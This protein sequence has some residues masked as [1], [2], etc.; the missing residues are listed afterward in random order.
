MLGEPC[1]VAPCER[2]VVLE[3]AFELVEHVAGSNLS[4]DELYRV[5]KMSFGKD[6]DRTRI[7]YNSHMTLDGIPEEASG[8]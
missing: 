6:K 5:E 4:D 8:T 1:D 2:A 3:P 7:I